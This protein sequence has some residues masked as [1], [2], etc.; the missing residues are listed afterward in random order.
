MMLPGIFPRMCASK[1][2]CKHT[3]DILTSS[4]TRGATKH[5]DPPSCVAQQ[6]H[7]LR[8]GR[9]P[10]CTQHPHSKGIYWNLA[11]DSVLG[12]DRE[13]RKTF[14]PDVL[15]WKGGTGDL[16]S[17]KVDCRS[18]HQTRKM[19][20]QRAHDFSYMTVMLISRKHFDVASFNRQRNSA[21]KP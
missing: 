8:I 16:R 3:C 19:V 20:G 17:P 13:V 15:T 4:T 10:F 1:F 14:G 18:G 21:N 7:L 9:P 12:R 5:G 6:G 2:F 11:H